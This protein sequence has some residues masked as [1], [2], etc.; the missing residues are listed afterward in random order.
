MAKFNRN[1]MKQLSESY[2]FEMQFPPD[3]PPGQPQPQPQPQPA[4]EPFIPPQDPQPTR[5]MPGVMSNV[6]STV[7]DEVVRR[8]LGAKNGATFTEN[9]VTYTYRKI[10]GQEYIYS[11]DVWW[12][13]VDGEWKLFG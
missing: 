12:R 4:P 6:P 8:F 3:I 1:W 13:L 5:P 10:N 2:I 7:P 9:G 11:G